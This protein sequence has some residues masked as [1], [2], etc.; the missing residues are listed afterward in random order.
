MGLL[1]FHADSKT[2]YVRFSH[3]VREYLRKIMEIKTRD[4]C[5]L[6]R[7]TSRNRNSWFGLDPTC[8]DKLKRAEGRLCANEL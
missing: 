8:L 2:K 1:Y 7:C 4:V 3:R 6:K 5:G